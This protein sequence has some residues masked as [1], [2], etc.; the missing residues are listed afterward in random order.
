MH[1]LHLEHVCINATTLIN[2][3]TQL[4]WGHTWKLNLTALS[5]DA[6]AAHVAVKLSF[7]V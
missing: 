5:E 2:G 1:Q 7:Q 3:G 6:S 4:S